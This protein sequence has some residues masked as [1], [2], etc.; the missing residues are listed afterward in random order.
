MAHRRNLEHDSIFTD[1]S[2]LAIELGEKLYDAWNNQNGTEVIDCV[3][4]IVEAYDGKTYTP[5][6]RAEAVAY[7][8]DIL[9]RRNG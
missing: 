9:W 1:A 5:R 6:L 2:P 4:A 8:L 7:A 3:A